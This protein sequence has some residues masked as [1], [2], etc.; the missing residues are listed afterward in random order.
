M[1][2]YNFQELWTRL[3]AEDWEFNLYDL[4]RKLITGGQWSEDERHGAVRLIDR[5]E[6]LGVF[7]STA[8]TVIERRD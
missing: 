5:L 1:P 7:G 8:A 2:Y 6:E 4:L 3:E